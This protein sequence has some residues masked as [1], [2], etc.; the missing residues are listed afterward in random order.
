[1]AQYSAISNSTDQGVV[2]IGSG[3]LMTSRAGEVFLVHV[4][5]ELIFHDDGE[6]VRPH[7]EISARNYI[8]VFSGPGGGK[9]SDAGC[10]S[11]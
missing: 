11:G 8:E 9:S 3:G 1:M 5:P 6:L 10:V 4:G 2:T 7:V